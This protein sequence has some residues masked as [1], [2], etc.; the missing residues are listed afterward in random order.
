MATLLRSRISG[1]DPYPKVCVCVCARVRAC[2]RETVRVDVFII[3]MPHAH[4]LTHSLTHP[5]VRVGVCIQVCEQFFSI[6][7]VWGCEYDCVGVGVG[8]IRIKTLKHV[9]MC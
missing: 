5:K 1:K 7:Y 8:V 4:T 9:K 2:V 3:C 6:V